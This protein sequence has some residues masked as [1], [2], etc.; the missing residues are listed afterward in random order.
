MNGSFLTA[1]V[2]Y[3]C[4]SCKRYNKSCI[5]ELDQRIMNHCLSNGDQNLWLDLCAT[6]SGGSKEYS[7]FF[8]EVE[9][10]NEEI[11]RVDTCSYTT[12]RYMMVN[13]KDLSLVTVLYQKKLN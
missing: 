2:K 4:R 12:R 5:I 3:I 1:I 6:N 11:I 9:K 13:N 10:L 7:I 8:L